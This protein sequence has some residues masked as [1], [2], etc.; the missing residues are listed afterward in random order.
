MDEPQRQ[1]SPDELVLVEARSTLEV[2]ISGLTKLIHDLAQMKDLVTSQDDKI[3]LLTVLADKHEIRITVIEAAI[4]AIAK[5]KP[6]PTR[7]RVN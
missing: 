4:E 3:K 1:P 2:L 5:L 6:P 7:G